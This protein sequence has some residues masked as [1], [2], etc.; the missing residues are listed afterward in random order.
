MDKIRTQ[1][2]D[3]YAANK[4]N[5]L[6]QLPVN[7]SFAFHCCP[8]SA[9]DETIDRYDVYKVETIGDAYMVVSGL[10]EVNG[11]RHVVEIALMSLDLLDCAADFT[12]PHRPE[13]K[14]QLRIGFHSGLCLVH[15]ECHFLQLAPADPGGP[16]DPVPIAP[17]IFSKSCSFQIIFWENPLF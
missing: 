17:K 15:F 3:F 12:I 8:C 11:N 16:G 13:E 5:A 10:P 6:L 4:L 9:F 2:D 14:L 7:D 1:L